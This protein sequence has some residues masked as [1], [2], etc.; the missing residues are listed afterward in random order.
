MNKNNLRALELENNTIKHVASFDAMTAKQIAMLNYRAASRSA[1]V[2]TQRLLARLRAQ[3]LGARAIG[4]DGVYRHFLTQGGCIRAE[5]FYD[6]QFAP[7]YDRSYLNAA[8]YDVVIETALS[9]AQNIDGAT[10]VG[11]GLIRSTALRHAHRHVDA[12]VVRETGG[13]IAP[14]I[15]IAKAASTAPSAIDRIRE[16]RRRYSDMLLLVG[17]ARVVASAMRKTGGQ[18]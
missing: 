14:V 17:D 12:I 4:G 15:V 1:I 3:G 18:S 11:R 10:V 5:E 7:G 2:S 9:Q 6:A 13:A 16:L 8:R